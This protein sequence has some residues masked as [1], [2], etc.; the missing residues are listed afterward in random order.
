MFRFVYLYEK[1]GYFVCV[2]LWDVVVANGWVIFYFLKEK[3]GVF[4]IEGVE[5]LKEGIGLVCS[6][7]R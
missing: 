5:D 6:V 3:Y 1:V 7:C 4:K 2:Y